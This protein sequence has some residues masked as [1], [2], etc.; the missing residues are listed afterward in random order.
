MRWFLFCPEYELCRVRGR[1]GRGEQPQVKQL[2][3][4]EVIVWLHLFTPMWPGETNPSSTTAWVISSLCPLQ[5]TKDMFQ[6]VRP[7]DS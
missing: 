3:R 7:G 1:R 6:G 5:H 2:F 4:D